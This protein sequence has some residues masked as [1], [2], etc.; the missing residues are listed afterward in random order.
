M[1]R[2]I[3]SRSP[4][5][6]FT[7]SCNCRARR[8]R[9]GAIRTTST[10]CK[11][12]RPASPPSCRC[13]STR[14]A[15]NT[16]PSGR[17]RKRSASGGSTSTP[18]AIR[19]G[20]QA[21]QAWGQLEAAKAQIEATKAQVAASEIALNGV[22]EEARVGQRT[23]LDVLN[24]QQD[25]VNA[26]VSLVTAERDRV[27][28]SYTVLAR[29]AACRHR[30]SASASR[31]TIRWC[32]TS[33]S[34]TAGRACA[35]LTADKV[36]DA[37][38]NACRRRHVHRKCCVRPAPWHSAARRLE[39]A[40][41]NSGNRGAVRNRCFSVGEGETGAVSRYP[42]GPKARYALNLIRPR[43]RTQ[44]G[45][46]ERGCGLCLSLQRHTNHRWRRSLPPSDGLSLTT[47]PTKTQPAACRS[48]AATADPGDRPH[49]C[50]WRSSRFRRLR[51]SLR[52]A[53]PRS[54]PC[55]PDS[56]RCLR[57]PA[58][59]RLRRQPTCLS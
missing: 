38:P 28:A 9:P 41:N 47:T 27:V 10:R 39:C 5:A 15:A 13:R 42:C 3:R 4:R 43:D 33:R 1:S 20:R 11:Q 32:I 6:R 53:R 49:P 23:T 59:Y 12:R 46:P 29:P 8:T 35:R 44:V 24:A 51:L 21:T 56:M 18:H 34:A 55:F 31:P 14:V 16:R 2:S 19:C 17:P 48:L 25:L 57:L 54:M 26:R 45:G 37:A 50:R 58:K 52:C 40:V 30:F 22:R 36:P 7:R